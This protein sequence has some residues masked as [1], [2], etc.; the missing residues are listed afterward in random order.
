[1]LINSA[2]VQYVDNKGKTVMHQA[3]EQVSIFIN[4]IKDIYLLCYNKG[5]A[6]AVSL[7]KAVKPVSVNDLDENG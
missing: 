7:I 1:M 3:A 2:S 6:K 4:T 5:S